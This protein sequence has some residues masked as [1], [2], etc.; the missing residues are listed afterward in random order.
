MLSAAKSARETPPRRHRRLNMNSKFLYGL[1]IFSSAFLLFQVQPMLGKMILPWFGGAA[2]VWI[3]CLLFFQVVLLLGY[4]YAH[5]LRR[6]FTARTQARVHASLLLAS[7]LVLPIVPRDSW[8]SSDFTDPAWHILWFWGSRLA[9]LIFSVCHQPTAASVVRA[10]RRRCRPLSLVCGLEH[11]LHA[12]AGQLPG[13]DGALVCHLPPGA[14]MVVGLRC[15]GPFM[16]GCV[17]FPPP[18]RTRASGNQRSR[19][20]PNGRCK[21]SGSAWQR[22]ARP[23]CWPSLTT[24][25]RTSLPFRCFG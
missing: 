7:L 17:A 14:G 22:A 5:F 20:R 2:G 9:C 13:S 18:G 24:F 11:R 15:R 12:G 1:V 21:L 10:E 23:C 16:R 25:R 6:I 3:V 8:R 19:P 4:S